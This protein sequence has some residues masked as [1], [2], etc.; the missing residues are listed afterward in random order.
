MGI[1]Q[2][3]G[4]FSHHPAPRRLVMDGL[5]DKLPVVLL[6]REVTTG[7]LDHSAVIKLPK[8]EPTDVYLAAFAPG[9]EF[10]AVRV[11][12]TS[13]GLHLLQSAWRQICAF[14]KDRKVLPVCPELGA[15][16]L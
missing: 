12:W 7:R 1:T 4:Q 14:R 6:V 13:E 9:P 15:T 8:F 10:V 11:Q 2:S 3:G 16:L 5:R